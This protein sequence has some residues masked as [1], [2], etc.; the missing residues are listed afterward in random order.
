MMCVRETAVFKTRIFG[1]CKKEEER[2]FEFEMN[3]TST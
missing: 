3:T 2:K 1:S